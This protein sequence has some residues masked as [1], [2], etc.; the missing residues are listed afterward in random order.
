MSF[1][2]E[3]EDDDIK[4]RVIR[5]RIKGMPTCKTKTKLKLACEVVTNTVETAQNCLKQ[6]RT[7]RLELL[8]LVLVLHVGTS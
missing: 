7:R 6:N 5:K 1:E 2:S 4:R 3:G 8:V